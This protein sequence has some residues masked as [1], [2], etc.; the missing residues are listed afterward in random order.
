MQTP[1]TKLIPF[2]STAQSGVQA[3]SVGAGVVVAG[4]AVV[5]A[6]V[7]SAAPGCRKA[8]S[9]SV[10]DGKTHTFSWGLYT[11]PGPHV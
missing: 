6:V 5:E 1:G 10:W 7:V 11:V 3:A 9:Q 2:A 8:A 4:A